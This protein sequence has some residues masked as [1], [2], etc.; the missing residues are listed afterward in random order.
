MQAAE[1][2]REWM[3][4][5]M[6]QGNLPMPGQPLDVMR[7]AFQH[8]IDSLDGLAPELADVRGLTFPGAAGPLNARLYT[9]LAS[10][11]APAAGLVFYH[12]GG[13][14]LCDLDTHDR[15]CRRLAAAS[16]TRIVSVEY[17]LAPKD[18]FP[19]AVDDALAA[20]DWAVGEGA[21]VLGFDPERVAV[22][23]DSAGGNLAAVV[24]QHRRK[25]DGASPA[26]QMLIY[27]L[28]QLAETNQKR[29]KL[30]EGHLMSTAVL[31]GVRKNYLG[32]DVDPNDPRASPLFCKDL[33]G[34]APTYMV[35]SGLDPLH[36][37]GRA[38]ADMLAA[39]GVPVEH[40]HY[41]AVPH[42][43]MQMT[44]VLDVA[45]EAVAAAGAAL[46]AGLALKESA[47]D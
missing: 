25:A 28:M 10:G 9:P 4:K 43:F 22:G 38:Y 24:A 14:V 2:W 26:L 23:G 29:A 41:G 3:S 44:A 21:E 15:F 36:D 27:P 13:F 19:A 11:A 6:D 35:T 33:T 47:A 46:E 31:D 37:E 17:R 8:G 18:K 42:G 32:P 12:G 20:F 40:A 30:L 7:V 5:L 16:H 1:N 45:R 39:A 34:V